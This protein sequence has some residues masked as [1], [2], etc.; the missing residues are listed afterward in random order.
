MENL[1]VCVFCA[2]SAKCDSAYLDAARR[3]GRHLARHRVT[4]V[5]GGGGVGAMASLA[6][7]ALEAA[8]TVIGVIPRFMYD[9]EWGHSRLTE[10][11]IV[12]DMRERKR[13]MVEDAHAIVALPGGSGTLE[14]LFETITLKRVGQFL[15][16]IVLV[17]TRG[18]YD[19]VLAALEHCIAEN[20]MDARHR[21]IW[22]VVN[23]PEEVMEAIQSAP[24]W[25]AENREFAVVKPRSQGKQ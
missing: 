15:R 25:S 12:E 17:N 2:S 8:G 14:E 16:P 1:K 6:D 11:R 24:R 5:Y 7:G 3:L 19:R 21:D 22:T 13:Q 20:F 23:E 10:M 9:L 18:F 4:V